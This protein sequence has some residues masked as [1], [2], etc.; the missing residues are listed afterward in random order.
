MN[1]TYIIAEAGV[2]HN[3]DLNRAKEMIRVA[4]KAGA[5]AVKFQTFVTENLV[6][7]EAPKATYQRKTTGKEETQYQMLKKLELSFNNF[8]ELK[9]YADEVGIDFLSTPFD[10]DSIDFLNQLSM[11]FWKIPSG[12]ITNK[13]YLVKISKTKRPIILSTGMSTMKE[14]EEALEIFK[15]YNREDIILLHCNTEYPTPYSDVNL[16]AMKTLKDKFNVL[17]GYSDHTKGIEVS[18]AAVALGAV[19][20][21]KHFTLDKGLPGPDH[22]A[23]LEPSEFTKMINSIRNIEKAIGDGVKKPSESETKNITIARKSIVAKRD[24]KKGEILTEAN[25][26]VKRPGNGISPMKWFDVLGKIAIHDFEKDEM[27]EI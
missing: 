3:G 7:V 15:D 20:I 17:I 13:P 1:K 11:R 24:I 19:V 5:D 10:E 21:E 26:A 6:S 12:E 22:K 16:G 4:Q 9:T 18:I 8:R 23:S 25:L 14:I 2:N 27:I